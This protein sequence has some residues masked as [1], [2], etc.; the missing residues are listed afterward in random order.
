MIALLFGVLAVLILLN[1]P[2]SLALGLA[3]TIAA[4]VQA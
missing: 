3:S 4:A 2:I 1:S